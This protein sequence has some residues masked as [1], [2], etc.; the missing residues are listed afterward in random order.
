MVVKPR[1]PAFVLAKFYA[2]DAVVI[3]RVVSGRGVGEVSV[4]LADVPPANW[5][6]TGAEGEGLPLSLSVYTEGD[7]FE[8]CIQGIIFASVALFAR[9]KAALADRAELRLPLALSMS[10]SSL[11]CHRRL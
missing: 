9:R 10:W 3:M 11:S 2:G 6:P 7:L 1:Q 4:G 5:E 8:A